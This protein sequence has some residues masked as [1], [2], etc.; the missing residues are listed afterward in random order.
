[1]SLSVSVLISE[2]EM[3]MLLL[4]PG[5]AGFSEL[6][7]VESVCMYCSLSNGLEGGVTKLPCL[8]GTVVAAVVVVLTPPPRWFHHILPVVA[9][10]LVVVVVVVL[11]PLPKG[12][13]DM[14]SLIL[15]PAAGETG[16]TPVCPPIVG[17]EEENGLLSL[18]R[19]DDRCVHPP[20]SEV[21]IMLRVNPLS[22]LGGEEETEEARLSAT[23][24]NRC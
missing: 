10:T 11:T 2:A 14:T 12:N 24:T 6:A 21:G 5:R 7:N 17:Y 3:K 9:A 22:L 1:M 15:L 18:S 13:V 4:P 19:M 23:L 20:L 8:L 16:P